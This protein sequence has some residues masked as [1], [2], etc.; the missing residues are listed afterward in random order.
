MNAVLDIGY[1]ERQAR[2]DLAA[3]HRL[4]VQFGFHEGICNHFT[5]MVPGSADRFLLAPY[6]LHWGE[7]RAADFLVVSCDG[8]VIS[9]TGIPEDTAFCIH[10][11]IHRLSPRARCI[12]HT[13]MPY[14]TALAMLEEP[15]LEMALQTSVGFAEHIAYDT[16][17]TGLAYDSTEGERLAAV[18]GDK[19]VLMMSNHGV[20]V[21]GETV[22][23][24]FERLYYLERA[25]QTQV[26]ALSTGRKLKQIPAQALEHT[27]DQFRRTGMMR[28]IKRSDA[29]FA[30]LKRTLL[31]ADPTYAE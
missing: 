1:D 4:A 9:G 10:A 17:Y 28:G 7:I 15:W 3:S 30:S 5:L 14:A 23:E 20:L 13:H 21:T 24:G 2:V 22:A 6:G 11:P 25:C 19:S 8:K 26:L 16:S 18:L 31:R 27:I 12:L 29:H